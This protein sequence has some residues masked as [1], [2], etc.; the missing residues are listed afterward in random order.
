MAKSLAA[1]LS[2]LMLSAASSTA[3]PPVSAPPFRIEVE[4]TEAGARLYCISGCNW[5]TTSYRC[6]GE[7]QRACRFALDE[8]GIRGMPVTSDFPSKTRGDAA[9]PSVGEDRE[10]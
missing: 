3:S 8:S 7:I 4:V 9:Q 1:V 6:G 5:I 2:V 10:R